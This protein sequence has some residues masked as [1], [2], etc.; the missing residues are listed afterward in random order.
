MARNQMATAAELSE[1]RFDRFS[2]ITLIIGLI[3]LAVSSVVTLATYTVPTD[4][5]KVDTGQ[6]VRYSNPVYLTS[7]SGANPAL[8]PGDVLLEVEGEAFELL[9]ARAANFR[10]RRPAAWESGGTIRYT[11]LRDDSEIVVPVTLQRLPLRLVLS[12]HILLSNGLLLTSFLY[13]LMGGLLFLLRPRQRA[14]QLLFLSAII[15]FVGPLAGWGVGAPHGVADLFSPATYWPRIAVELSWLLL[16]PILAHLF[17]IFPL[18]KALV[19]RSSLVIPLVYGSPAVIIL[20]SVPLDSLGIVGGLAVAIAYNLLYLLIIAFSLIHSLLVIKEPVPRMQMRWIAFGGLIGIV[21]SMVIAL[22]EE[23]R[24][25]VISASSGALVS[26]DFWF[27]P[28]IFLLSS[29]F[30]ISLAVAILRYRLWDIDIII[31]RSLVYGSLT[32]VLAFIYFGSVLL[33][34]A[35]FRA[36]TGQGSPIAIVISTL[37]IAG[38]FSPLRRRVQRIIDRRFYRRKYDAQQI[39]GRFAA[40]ARSETDLDRLTEELIS[41]TKSSMQAE[42]VSIW[43]RDPTSAMLTAA[44]DHGGQTGKS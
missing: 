2:W 25:A 31:N 15:F 3:I 38:L 33:L 22:A 4:G 36:L 7:L 11:L 14:S 16:W 23:A 9:E 37:V 5:W 43:L 29:T 32:G 35:L 24:K 26:S 20:V 12:P 17:L 34:Q 1:R 21:G 10:L 28:L 30:P 27:G 42:H 18:P 8:Q 13:A 39:L 19:Q 6:E 40:S 44:A 41:V